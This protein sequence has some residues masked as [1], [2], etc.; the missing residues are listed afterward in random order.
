VTPTDQAA[1]GAYR[2]LESAIMAGAPAK[3]SPA[4][5]GLV[6]AFTAADATA[7]AARA[8]AGQPRLN[9]LAVLAAGGEA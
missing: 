2:A 7:Q 1:V 6:R 9:Y 8:A 4:R 5:V 3:G